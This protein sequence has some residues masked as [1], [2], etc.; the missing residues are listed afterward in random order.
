MLL[1]EGLVI[2]RRPDPDLRWASVVADHR[3]ARADELPVGA[4]AGT[5]CTVPVVD[6][7]RYLPWLRDHAH[8]RGVTTERRSIDGLDDVDA[9]VIVLAAG[10]RSAGLVGDPD[11][12]PV[13]GQIVRVDESRPHSLDL[14]RR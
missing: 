4:P 7:G 1:R 14:G 12:Y 13:R 11:V 3:P 2:H 10:L 8:A 9:D 6:T 5:V